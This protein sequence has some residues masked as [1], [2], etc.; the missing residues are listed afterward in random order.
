MILDNVRYIDTYRTLGPYF[1]IAIDFLKTQDLDSYAPGK[2]SIQGNDVYC[3]VQ[4][5]VNESEPQ[6]WE[7]H[8]EYVD[9]QF[10]VAGSEQIG[11]YP[12]HNLKVLPT[13]IN[14]TDNAV[15]SDL[16]GTNYNLNSGDYL[17]LFPHDVHKPNCPGISSAYSKKIIVKVRIK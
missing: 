14:G 13:F 3:I 15:I 11:V 17:I 9:I 8:Q 2:Y 10:I 1:P 4:E 5:Q 12:K 16:D 6:I 7:M